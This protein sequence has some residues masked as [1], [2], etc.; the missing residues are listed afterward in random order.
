[1][2]YDRIFIRISWVAATVAIAFSFFR[3][4]KTFYW[5]SGTTF[6]RF[7]P[8]WSFTSYFFQSYLKLI[9]IKTFIYRFVTGPET[10]IDYTICHLKVKKEKMLLLYNDIDLKRFKP[11]SVEDKLELKM[12]LGFS[13]NDK[14]LLYVKRLSPIKGVNYYFPYILDRFYD[15]QDDLGF[16][17]VIIGN[18]SERD[19]LISN[20]RFKPYQRSVIILGGV[21]NKDVQNYYKISDIFINCTLEEGFPRVLIEA[22]ASGLPVVSTDVGGIRDILG[23]KQRNFMTDAFDLD[24]FSD[25]LKILSSMPE[26]EKRELITENLATVDKFSTANVAKMYINSLFNE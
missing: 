1:M 22:M 8:T 10:M 25:K 13:P 11:T 6:V 2:G 15:G 18:G 9:F 17:V 21:P 7:S 5:L 16:K 23:N 19:Q 4:V 14:I 3:R 26:V 20:L 24:L 12:Q